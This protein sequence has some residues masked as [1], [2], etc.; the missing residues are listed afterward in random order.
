MKKLRRA[1]A[2]RRPAEAGFTIVELLVY[3]VLSVIVLLIV[4]GILIKSLTVERSVREASEASNAGQLVAT[5]VSHGVRNANEIWQ[6]APGVV[7]QILMVRTVGSEETPN[8]RCQAWSY[9]SGEIRT[10]T[11]ATAIST[12][13]TAD[14][15]KSWMLL[16]EGVQPLIV[17]AVPAPV[18]TVVGPRVDLGL[19]MSTSQGQPVLISTSSVSR[20]PFEPIGGLPTCIPHP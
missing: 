16:A 14:S 13:Q 10:T 9:D 19:D 8:W 12:I 4:G 5:S 6:S 17:A 2:D 15:V 1:L 20:H 18:F 11:S 3:S 7:P